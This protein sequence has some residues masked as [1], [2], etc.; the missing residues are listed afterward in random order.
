MFPV[1]E[2]LLEC[3]AETPDY[4][5]AV[6]F[7]PDFELGSWRYRLLAE[8]LFVWL[9]DVALQSRER[10][11]LLFQPNKQL[12]W[13]CR[14]L[15]DV[16]NPDKRGEI[17]EI[18]LHALCRQEFKTVPFVARLFFKMRTNDSITSIDVAHVYYDEGTAKLELWIGEA[19]L[20]DDM[21]AAR[22]AALSSIRPLWD[23]AFLKEMKAL[24][25]PKIDPLCPFKEQLNALF[26]DNAS[27]DQII[28][29][30]VVPICLAADFPPTVT[31]SNRSAEYVTFVEK[32]MLAARE[33]F[34]RRVPAHVTFVIF[35]V[36]LDSKTKLETAVN[37]RVI[38]YL[39]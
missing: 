7:C 30:I 36:P 21:Q 33:Y 23:N 39:R 14:R 17:G 6:S 20:Y 1:P 9:P 10:Q 18:I 19:K 32:E 13:S 12:A 24:I 31:S 27:L 11:A 3:I 37:D 15:F 28:S 8:H 16:A 2:A 4:P 22:Y 38:T 29:K 5:L 35:L 34:V 26:K 25:G